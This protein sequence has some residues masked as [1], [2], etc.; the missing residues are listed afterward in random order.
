MFIKIKMS[1]KKIFVS[2]AAMVMAAGVLSAQ[3]INTVTESYNNG[4]ME[5]EM[6]NKEAA[7]EQ[8]L[9]S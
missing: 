2:F 7:L 9:I 3:D 5:L 1:M 4:A 8:V 6:G